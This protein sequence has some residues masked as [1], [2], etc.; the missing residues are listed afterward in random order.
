MGG[1]LNEKLSRLPEERRERILAEA[2]RLHTE[3]TASRRTRPGEKSASRATDGEKPRF[4][5]AH[6]KPLPRGGSDD[7]R[8]LQALKTS[9]NRAKGDT[10]VK[11]SRHNQA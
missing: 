3:Y 7:T 4:G 1:S 10:L 8:N 6:I 2:K 11:R 9:V 5:K